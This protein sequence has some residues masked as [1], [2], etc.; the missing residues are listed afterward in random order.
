MPSRVPL[1]A[2]PPVHAIEGAPG[3][4]ATPPTLLTL[5]LYTA[6]QYRTPL[7]VSCWGDYNLGAIR[8]SLRSALRC[9]ARLCSIV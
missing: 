4:E 5:I 2:R 3:G 9:M 6:A 7:T 8:D 1:V